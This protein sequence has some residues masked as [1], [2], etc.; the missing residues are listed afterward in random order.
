MFKVVTSKRVGGSRS[1]GYV[2]LW[3]SSEPRPGYMLWQHVCWY[4]YKSDATRGAAVHN[5]ALNKGAAS[6]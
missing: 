1:Y 3:A 5:A 4:R 2:L 6:C